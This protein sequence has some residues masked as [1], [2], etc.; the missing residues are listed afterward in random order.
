MRLS[1]LAL[2]PTQ[3]FF[4]ILLASPEDLHAAS[5]AHFLCGN[6]YRPLLDRCPLTSKLTHQLALKPTQL[7]LRLSQLALRATQLFF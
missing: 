2:R 1:Q 6:G 3:L 7:H 5:A 4:K